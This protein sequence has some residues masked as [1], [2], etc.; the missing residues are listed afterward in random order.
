MARHYGNLNPAKALIWRIV[1]RDNLPWIFDHGLHC[2]SSSVKDPGYVQIGN[3]DLIE[4]RRA[5]PVPIAPGGNLA[6]YVPFY[7]TPFSPMLLNIITGRNVARRAKD[8]LCILVSSLLRL[9]DLGLPFVFTDRHAY[10]AKASFSS[11]LNDLSR[12]DWPRLQARNFRRDPDDPERFERYEAEALVHAHVPVTAL[13][14]VVCHDTA[15]GATIAEQ[16]A[17]RSLNVEAVVRPDWYF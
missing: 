12:I 9:R 11:D 16:I 15:S 2:A 6:D 5:K 3:P 13:L 1:H 17:R 14:G 10:L 4:H 8:E 7:F